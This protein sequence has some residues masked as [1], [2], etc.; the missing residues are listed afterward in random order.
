MK[1]SLHLP[2]DHVHQP[3]EFLSASAIAEMANATEKAG[4]DA[5]YVTEHPAPVDSWLAGNGHHALDPFVALSFAAAATTRL[6]LHTNILVLPYRNPWLTAKAVATLDVLSGGRTILGIGAG[7]VEGEFKALNAPFAG[8]G[9]VMDEAVDLMK[10]IW[11]GRSVSVAGT[12]FQAEG[13]TAL[14]TP[15][16][17]PHPPIWVGGNSDRALRRAVE[18]CD[19]WAPFQVKAEHA[20]QVRTEGLETIADLQRK[21]AQAKELAAK[22][23]RKTPV[24]ICLVPYALGMQAETRPTAQAV[25]DAMSELE[26][27][28][29]TWSIISFPSRSRVEYLENVHWFAQE[30]R[31]ALPAR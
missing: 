16:Q 12:H 31:A 26:E 28:G 15:L 25:I 10:Q 8:R 17:T 9:A 30:V 1:F 4:I 22:I 3:G 14:P 13:N 29:V 6:K 7:H 19:G 2:V 5:V 11:G 23:G 18:T 20:G 21:I 27:I 24:E